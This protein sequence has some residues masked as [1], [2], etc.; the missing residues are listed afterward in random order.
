MKR[1]FKT[2]HKAIQIHS[3]AIFSFI[4]IILTGLLL[5]T[6]QKVCAQN[7][8]ESCNADL[9][10]LMKSKAYLEAKRE[11]EIAQRLILKP[12]STLEHSCFKLNAIRNWY[13]NAG[14]FTETASFGANIDTTQLDQTIAEMILSNLD[15]YLQANFGH[16]YLG[17]TFPDSVPSSNA[18]NPMFWVWQIAKCANI[19]VKHFFRLSN[20]EI[21]DY[22]Q[23]YPYARHCEGTK[24]RR[25]SKIREEQE[26]LN[27][28]LGSDKNKFVDNAAIYANNQTYRERLL[29]CGE[30]IAVGRIVKFNVKTSYWE[31]VDGVCVTPGCTY[32]SPD[33]TEN[34]LTAPQTGRCVPGLPRAPEPVN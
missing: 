6:P 26:K 18:C 24:G 11:T 21:N 25:D 1:H 9:H 28:A 3:G 7:L 8:P 17:G 31:G 34:P 30:P 32:E 27:D 13:A 14:V 23:S 20:L 12:D 19:S 10:E 22:R 5:S 16:R 2:G 29:Q 15:P 4:L 33:G